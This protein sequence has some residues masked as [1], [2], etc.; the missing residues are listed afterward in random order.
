MRARLFELPISEM[1]ATRAHTR[2][3][4]AFLLFL[5]LVFSFRFQ[6]G[7]KSSTRRGSPFLVEKDRN[8]PTDTPN[9]VPHHIGREGSGGSQRQPDRCSIDQ[10]PAMILILMVFFRPS[11]RRSA[12]DLPR[13]Y[14]QKA[15][16]QRKFLCYSFSSSF[17]FPSCVCVCCLF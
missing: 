4:L 10:K 16:W 6:Q 2:D 1:V 14:K 12:K 8:R 5:S 9:T 7:C 3:P 17:L 13:R 15:T 11:S